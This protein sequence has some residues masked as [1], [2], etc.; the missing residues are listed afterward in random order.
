[1]KW[2]NLTGIIAV[3]VVNALA[4]ILP[5]NGLNTGEISGMFPNLFVPAGITFSIWSV[6]YL[7]LLGYCLY[8][9]IQKR[10]N[11]IQG[12]LF[13]ITCLLNISWILA[14]HHLLIELS[15]L[16]MISLLVTL[17][18]I[19]LNTKTDNR[20]HYWLIYVPI[21]IYFAWISVATIANVT[22]LFVHWELNLPYP[23][24]IA[25]AMITITQLLVWQINLRK[26]NWPY[27]LVI[28]WALSG[29]IIK[30]I[31]T[32]PIYLN[33]MVASIAAIMGTLF[34]TILKGR[35]QS[36]ISKPV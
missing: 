35:N 31:N 7:G 30:R 4:N 27:S 13:F 25:M 2:I 14:W 16:I 23:A 34:I 17:I 19:Y 33:I 32:E 11:N 15:V 26:V 29:I 9:F 8:P 28:I 20:I 10:P 21:N 36:I 18:K 1:M 22:A 24:I 6:I 3:I 5:I 12:V